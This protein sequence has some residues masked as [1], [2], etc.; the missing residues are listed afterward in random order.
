MAPTTMTFPFRS[1]VI[2]DEF[3]LVYTKIIFIC[4]QNSN[5]QNV[6][7]TNKKNSKQDKTKRNQ[8]VTKVKTQNLTKL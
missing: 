3:I 1:N 4:V 2:P 8:N 6:T 7:T 5:T